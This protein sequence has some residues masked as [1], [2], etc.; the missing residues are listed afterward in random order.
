MLI[1][2]RRFHYMYEMIHIIQQ[3]KHTWKSVFV[4]A[5]Q[6]EKCPS[7]AHCGVGGKALQGMH[8]SKEVVLGFFCFFLGT[9][10]FRIP[11][12]NCTSTLY[13]SQ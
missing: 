3:K 5:I 4:V 8:M 13:S 10:T 11:F 9:N 7:A 2:I 6:G 1:D 12:L